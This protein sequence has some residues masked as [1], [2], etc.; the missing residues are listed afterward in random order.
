MSW[1][2]QLDRWSSIAARVIAIGGF[3]VVVA[4]AATPLA[5]NWLADSVLKSTEFQD[6]K[7]AE[8]GWVLVC[9]TVPPPRDPP[10]P[11]IPN[12]REAICP[13]GFVV[14]GC[15]AGRNRGSIEHLDDRCLTDDPD[16]GWTQARCCRLKRATADST[17]SD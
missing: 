9:E 11:R 16:P 14:T 6:F 10:T 12:G 1:K 2:E 5:R 8:A 4:T 13:P 17:N 7:A 3:A 15:S